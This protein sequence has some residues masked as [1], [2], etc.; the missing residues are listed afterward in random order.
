M[1]DLSQVTYC[2]LYCGLC[3]Q[4]CRVPQQAQTLRDTMQKEAWDKWGKFLPDFEAFWKFLNNLATD[5]QG[6]SCRSGQC[7]PPFCGIRK[8][9][10]QKGVDVCPFCGEYPCSRIH[11]IA[12]GY[13]T[14]LADGARMK[15]V[16][17]DA[18]IAEQEDRR[19][20]GFA[21]CDIRCYPYEVPDK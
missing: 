15:S 11:A 20:T 6:R 8:C 10:Q 9:A 18:W 14:L 19:K 12:Q 2:G 1:T 4:R 5:D 13:P 16:G 17:L 3:A 21:Y 7:G